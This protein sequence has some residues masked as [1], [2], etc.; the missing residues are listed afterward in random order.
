MKV[1]TV[2]A[3]V[4]LAAVT[5]MCGVSSSQSEVD[6]SSAVGQTPEAAQWDELRRV[7]TERIEL[8]RDLVEKNKERYLIGELGFPAVSEAQRELYGAEYE[9]A[10]VFGT[11]Q[12][13]RAALQRSLDAAASILEQTEVRFSQGTVSKADLVHARVSVADARLAMLRDLLADGGQI[14]RAPRTP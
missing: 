10:R 13:R 12:Q 3:A 5:S 14:P 2:F 6:E 7:M 1:C 11:V 9:F 4:F 8:L